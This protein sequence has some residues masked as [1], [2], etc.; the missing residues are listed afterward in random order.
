[1]NGYDF[2]LSN[3][4]KAC[5]QV[6]AFRQTELIWAFGEPKPTL[7]LVKCKNEMHNKV[8]GAVEGSE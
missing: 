1:M 4:S 5:F 6:T 8:H 2:N 3:C 7:K